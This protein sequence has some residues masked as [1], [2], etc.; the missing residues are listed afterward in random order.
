MNYRKDRDAAESVAE[1]IRLAGGQAAVVAADVSDVTSL[2][3]LLSQ[4]SGVDDKF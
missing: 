3:W 4:A 1:A 2:P